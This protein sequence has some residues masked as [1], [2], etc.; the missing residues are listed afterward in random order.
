MGE[1]ENIVRKVI[2]LINKAPDTNNK[3][4]LGDNDSGRL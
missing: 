2:Y 3:S 1:E 4:N